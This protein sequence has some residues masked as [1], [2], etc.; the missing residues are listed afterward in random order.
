MDIY[1][2]IRARRNVHKFKT[3]RV[4]EGKLKKILEAGLQASSAF[5][6]QPWE[7]IVVTDEE[8]IK[9]LA[10][11]KYDHNMQGLLASKI[12]RQEAEKLAGAQRD[13]FGNSVPVVLI[14][15]RK[16]KLPVESSWNCITTVWLVACAE[17]LGMSPA[18][19]GL[20]SQGTLKETLGVPDGY[21]IAA[22]LRFG[23]PEL[24][25]DAKPRKS[26]DACLHYN[27]F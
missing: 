19:F 2:A 18:Y 20:P 7:F 9:K 17:G 5:N 15:D 14:Y 27:R 4:P 12:P 13:A 24:I 11:Y 8:L 26:L 25:P 16:K 3:E 1:E 23:V 6:E 21:D 22:I 10:Q